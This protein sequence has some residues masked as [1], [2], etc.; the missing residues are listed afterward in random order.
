M[1]TAPPSLDWTRFP[2]RDSML[3]NMMPRSNAPNGKNDA[4]GVSPPLPPTRLLV[5]AFARTTP[6][7]EHTLRLAATCKLP[8]ASATPLLER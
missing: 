7:L 1:L 2:P 4:T 5:K 8:T 6:H 3:Q